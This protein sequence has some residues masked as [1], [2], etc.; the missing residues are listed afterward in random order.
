MDRSPGGDPMT[1]VAIV[2]GGAAGIGAAKVLVDAGCEVTIVESAPRLGGNCVGVEVR[3][4]AGVVHRIDAGVSDFNRGTFHE[5]SRLI[6]GLGVPTRPISND[7]DFVAADG[8]SRLS[9]RDG[10]WTFGPE[11][12]DPERLRREIDAFRARAVE[13]LD[14]P[15]FAAWSVERYLGYLG[16]SREFRRLYLYPR[17][18]GCFPMPDGD[19]RRFSILAL[20]QF[21]NAH[22]LVGSVP[23][24]R[25][26]VV[27]GMHR[28][29]EAYSN[30]FRN[31]GG[32]LLCGARVASIA[33]R[34]GRVEV[35]TVDR[36]GRARTLEADHVILACHAHQALRLLERPSLGEQRLLGRFA[37]Q[38]ARLV[39]HR[40]ERLLGADRECWGAFNYLVPAG[41]WPRV[42]PTI[43]F[44]PNRLASLPAE[45]PDTFVTMNPAREP[46]ADR[47]LADRSFV[48]PILDARSAE[49]ARR[50]ETLQGEQRTWFA[51]AYLVTPAVHESAMV[52]GLRAAHGLLRQEGG[53]DAVRSSSTALPPTGWQDAA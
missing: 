40:D 30:W 29:V 5:V 36:A 38:R 21:W 12:R 2:G 16:S 37:C 18:M 33:R 49:L 35:C 25:H 52:S 24:D 27:G 4:A 9:C 8:R 39:V 34:S 28:Y 1:R 41:D 44:F 48:H 22:G 23:A 43:T 31:R 53:S 47:V 51:G 42:R 11:V 10:L 32:R 50:V 20:L 19:P 3:D 15:R 14:D 46:R 26:T 17:A 45:V 13:A 6:D 7:T